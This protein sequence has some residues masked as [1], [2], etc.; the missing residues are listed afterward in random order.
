[1][2]GLM[3]PSVAKPNLSR[4][5]L[6]ITT[7]K[8]PKSLYQISCCVRERPATS[9]EVPSALNPHSIFTPD[10]LLP[11]ITSQ[12]SSYSILT[13]T[14]LSRLRDNYSTSLIAYGQTGSGKTH[15]VFGPPGCL[16]SDSSPAL[17]GLLPRLLQELVATANTTISVSAVEVYQDLAYDLLDS[18]SP[19][20]VGTKGGG[21]M[22]GITPSCAVAGPIS[23]TMGA[24]NGAHPAGCYCRICENAKM[25]KQ[26]AHK[27]KM[28]EIR[29]ELYVKPGGNPFAERKKKSVKESPNVARRVSGAADYATVGEKVTALKTV[30]D[31]LSFC[32]SVE[33][34]RTTTSHDLNERSSR[35]HCLITTHI[36]TITNNEK[37]HNTCLLVDLAGSERIAKSKVQGA[38]KAQ[39]IEINK[40][41]TALGRVVKSLG[42]GESHVPYRDS[43]LTMLLRDSF[44][45][46][47]ST[48]VV[49]CT[50]G[51][52]AHNEESVRS[53]EFGK[54]LGG[55]RS[56]RVVKVGVQSVAR[57]A[58]ERGE[59]EARLRER[60]GELELMDGG[61]VDPGASTPA[62]VA[63]FMKELWKLEALKRALKTA[64][65]SAYEKGGRR[66]GGGRAEGAGSASMRRR[67]AVEIGR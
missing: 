47:A 53:L 1:M 12:D 25:V 38:A 48:T 3:L 54:R 11:P 60:R 24:M 50:A 2:L 16:R 51:V 41:L 27:K 42:N 34:S 37:R 56:K 44:G 28:C 35:S 19:L 49:V 66:R 20:T 52:A 46:R 40:S 18:S 5:P 7:P 43:T 6:K 65:E 31:I 64:E 21:Q 59:V 10:Q 17:H 57:G 4:R 30:S 39:A 36:T 22:T 13:A 55:V 67:G 58:E 29:G 63:R 33:L 45:G 62:Q 61:G 23:S 8:S 9:T 15:T 14:L 26:D 32:R